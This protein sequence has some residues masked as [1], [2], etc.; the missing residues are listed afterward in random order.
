MATDMTS[1]LRAFAFKTLEEA[2]QRGASLATVQAATATLADVTAASL[3]KISSN[4]PT[5]STALN[6]FRV[7][8]QQQ[9]QAQSEQQ[10]SQDGYDPNAALSR[11]LRQLGALLAG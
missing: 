6:V 7:P 10:Q 2:K 11:R 9:Q 3:S 8:Q 4:V 1:A 5:T